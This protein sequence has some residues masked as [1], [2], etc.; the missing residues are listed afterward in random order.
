MRVKH[1]QE[2]MQIVTRPC[3][4]GPTT[5][6]QRKIYTKKCQQLFGKQSM[7][8]RK[9]TK[10]TLCQGHDMKGH[11]SS[12]GCFEG[13]PLPLEAIVLRDPIEK[14]N[15]AC[16]EPKEKERLKSAC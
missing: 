4:V 1:E 15:M 2:I 14:K 5:H 10:S 3:Q 13:P 9:I 8:K 6:T 12:I 16:R 11:S 7:K